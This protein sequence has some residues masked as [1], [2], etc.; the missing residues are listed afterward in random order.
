MSQFEIISKL[1]VLEQ[2][3]A[4]GYARIEYKVNGFWSSSQLTVTID[5]RYGKKDWV[6]S[7]SNASGGQDDSDLTHI[8]RLANYGAAMKAAADLLAYWE[9]NQPSLDAEY[10]L[11]ELDLMERNRIQEEER[12]IAR[13][14]AA[15]ERKAKE[16]AD[17]EF[18]LGEEG[19]KNLIAEGMA[20]I[21]DHGKWCYDVKFRRAGS[22]HEKELVEKGYTWSL[23]TFSAQRTGTG[24]VSFFICNSR[25]SKADALKIMEKA[26]IINN[27]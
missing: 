2:I 4:N 26:I 12:R 11:F 5:K 3:N 17:A 9:V 13:E 15:A 23:P 19:A 24:R 20:A 8:E 21:K 6:F 7:Y 10:K 14:K 1:G 18:V 27:N 16:E 25:Y 22:D